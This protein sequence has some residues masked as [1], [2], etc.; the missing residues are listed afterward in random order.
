MAK[1]LKI[2]CSSTFPAWQVVVVLSGRFALHSPPEYL[3]SDNGPEFVALA[4]RGWQQAQTVYV[5]PGCP[6]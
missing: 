5:A 2:R 6:W 3:R 1:G 4:V